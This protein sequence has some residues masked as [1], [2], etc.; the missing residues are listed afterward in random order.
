MTN[1]YQYSYET[2]E[3]YKYTVFIINYFI[4]LSG[5]TIRTIKIHGFRSCHVLFF[6]KVINILCVCVKYIY[7]FF[8]LGIIL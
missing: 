4:F 1:V 3:M 8:V 5:Q 2:T 6:Q 7:V